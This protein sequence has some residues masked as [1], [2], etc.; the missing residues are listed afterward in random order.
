MLLCISRSLC[1]ADDLQSRPRCPALPDWETIVAGQGSFF[2]FENKHT[3][4]PC[5]MMQTEARFDTVDRLGVE[6]QPTVEQLN[7]PMS[8]PILES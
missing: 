1:L 4:S 6:Y 7:V 3:V 5:S 2:P 8:L